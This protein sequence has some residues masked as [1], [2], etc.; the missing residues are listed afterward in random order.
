MSKL[1][2]WWYRTEYFWIGDT[3]STIIIAGSYH[4]S[5][6]DYPHWDMN[7][8]LKR[9]YLMHSAYWCQQLIVLLLG[10]EKPRKDYTELVAHHFVT[11]WLIGFVLPLTSLELVLNI[12]QLELFD[13]LDSHRKRSLHEHG[14]SRRIL[15][16]MYFFCYFSYSAVL[17]AKQLSKLF[18]YMQWERPKAVT[19]VVFIGVWTYVAYLLSFYLLA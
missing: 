5:T 4:T 15:G 7:P 1:P 17:I 14:Y 8:Q 10:L 9:Y 3:F 12:S 13:Q 18:N 11:L 6:L 16:G 2:T 19:F